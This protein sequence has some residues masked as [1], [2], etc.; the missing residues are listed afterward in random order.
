MTFRSCAVCL[1]IP[2]DQKIVFQ[3]L[4]KR[5]CLSNIVQDQT[6]PFLCPSPT[7]IK[8]D[9]E[10]SLM[11]TIHKRIQMF[12]FLCFCFRL[13]LLFQF[14]R[15]VNLQYK[16]NALFTIPSKFRLMV[17]HFTDTA[18]DYNVIIRNT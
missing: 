18:C 15:A 17:L 11:V 10:F 5:K 16:E 12:G 3:P 14:T 4:K 2:N 13:F 8:E 9:A 1:L 7:F 6:V